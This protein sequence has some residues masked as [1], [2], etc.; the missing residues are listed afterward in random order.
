MTK[1]VNF[2]VTPEDTSLL[3]DKLRHIDS[4]VVLH[5]R[6]SNSKPHELDS[7]DYVENGQQW[8]YFYLVRQDDFDSVIMRH[9]PAQNYWTV[10]VVKSPVIEFNRCFFDGKILRRGRI[11]YI[12]KFYGTNDELLEKPEPFQIWAKSIFNTTKKS[13]DKVNSDYYGRNAKAW[14]SSG[15]T[16]AQ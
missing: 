11:Y 12:N 3:E 10:D 13:L 9:V 2:Y 16:L 1:Q 5:S 4:L 6:S 7:L 14:I 15:G 8:L